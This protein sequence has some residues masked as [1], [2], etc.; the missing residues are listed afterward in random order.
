MFVDNGNNGGGNAD[1]Y[2]DDGDK[3]KCHC[4]STIFGLLKIST[5][6]FSWWEAVKR[7]HGAVTPWFCKEK[8]CI[9]L[10]N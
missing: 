5:L 6:G 10:R 3:N 2:D 4:V 7:N 1:V 8:D 9:F